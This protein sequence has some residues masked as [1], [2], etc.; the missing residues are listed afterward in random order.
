MRINGVDADIQME[1]EKTVGEVLAALENWLAGSGHCLSGL[2]IDGETAGVDTMEA[3][4]DRDIAGIAILDISTNAMSELFAES[5]LTTIQ[6]ID[7]YEAASYEEKIP[8]AAN[9]KE[10]PEARLLAEQ[11]PDL[12]D[13]TVKT[14]SGEG[15]GAHILRSL[16]EERLRELQD[17]A[18]ELGSIQKL[19]ADTC[20]RL[21]DLPLD[22]QTG[23]DARAAETVNLFSGI[24]EKVFRVF[25]VLRVEGFPV[26][27]IMV[28]ETPVDA[29]I[30]E[31]SKALRELLTA[32]EQ[33]DTVL[34]GDIAEYEMAPRLRGLHAAVLQAITTG[35]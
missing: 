29:Y 30:A 15:A 24:A 8:F 9:W 18:G 26:T 31:F 16:A 1:T 14:F 20:A 28:G 22:I 5:L 13:W 10:S 35:E 7:A 2:C 4:F 21:E 34:A 17:P 27:E 25:N 12:Y 19:V 33:R 6:D 23:K 3:C 32:Y 11:S